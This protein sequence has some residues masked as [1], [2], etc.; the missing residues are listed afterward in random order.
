MA[1]ED[2]YRLEEE[3]QRTEIADYLERIAEGVRKGSVS[4]DN[5]TVLELP[6]RLVLD[7]DVDR[8]EKEKGTATSMEIELKWFSEGE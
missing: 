6:E 2:L 8:H 3:R 1:K 7:V 4:F 5:D